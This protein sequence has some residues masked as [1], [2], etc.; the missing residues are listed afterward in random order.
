[1]GT[2]RF[3]V[4]ECRPFAG[5]A[6]FGEV[7]AYEQVD[8]IA[9]LTVD[10]SD[11]SDPALALITD[12]ERAARG[13]DGLVHASADVRI[14]RPADPARGNRCLLL[15]VLNR[16]RPLALRHLNFAPRAV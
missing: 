2:V 1:M 7:G 16:G 10:P 8:G 3:E 5:G 14:L 15:D 11:R 9:E 13:A 4:T 6:T 12:L